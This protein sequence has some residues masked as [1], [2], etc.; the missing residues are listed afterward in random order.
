MK[1]INWRKF[2]APLAVLY[3]VIW[4]GFCGWAAS[5]NKHNYWMVEREMHPETSA[6]PRL[7][8]DDWCAILASPAFTS[9]SKGE[10][11]ALVEWKFR[12]MKGVAEGIGYDSQAVHSWLQRTAINFESYPIETFVFMQ[13]MEDRYRD[14]RNT[15]FPKPNVWRVFLRHLFSKTSMGFALVALPF[16]GIPLLIV[17]GVVLAL[18][19]K[20]LAN[21]WKVLVVS[22]IA[23]GLFE[24]WVIGFTQK[25]PV[26]LG[27]FDFSDNGNYVMVEGTWTSDTDVANPLQISKLDC[28]QNWGYCIE[29]N[30]RVSNGYLRVYTDYWEVTDWGQDVLTIKDRESALC[31]NESLRID[32]KNKVAIFTRA[33]KQ[34]KPDSCADISDEPIVMHLAD[35]IH[36][37]FKRR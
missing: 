3:V 32:R 15:G 18:F 25:H 11:D 5:N 6:L 23:V 1:K 17:T 33:T 4:V 35:G 21:R 12:D 30:A 28:W 26:S 20:T 29:A 27:I 37:Q 8:K 9:K 34:P 2:L 31:V 36:V 14:L 16:I 22:L 19:S 24:A 7:D 13:G 10:R